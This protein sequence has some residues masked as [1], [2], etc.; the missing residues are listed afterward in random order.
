MRQGVYSEECSQ[1]TGNWKDAALPPD[2]VYG[3]E[4]VVHVLVLVQ[5]EARTHVST[6]ARGCHMIPCSRK[7]TDDFRGHDRIGMC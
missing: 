2:S 6:G 1:R 3:E 5:Y 4:V 7:P